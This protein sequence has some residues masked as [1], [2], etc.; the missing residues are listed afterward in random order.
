MLLEQFVD[1][2]CFLRQ[3]ETELSATQLPWGQRCN[4]HAC[5]L[6]QSGHSFHREFKWNTFYIISYRLPSNPCRPKKCKL[7]F[8][9]LLKTRSF[10]GLHITL[11]SLV[12]RFLV[13]AWCQRV[14]SN[15]PQLFMTCE[16]E[17]KH[18]AA[19]SPEVIS[20]TEAFPVLMV[21]NMIARLIQGDHGVDAPGFG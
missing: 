3:T 10:F 19:E 8:N 7:N 1:T 6:T 15:P 2:R 5:S 16:D 4:L 13:V 11:R 9:F 17:V 20:H 12:V 21:P 18:C 14:P